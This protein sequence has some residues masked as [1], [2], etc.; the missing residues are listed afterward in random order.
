MEAAAGRA[1]AGTSQEAKEVCACVPY[2]LNPW[3]SIMSSIRKN[4]SSSS[5][6]VVVVIL[7]STVLA[8]ITCGY[9][10]TPAHVVVASCIIKGVCALAQPAVH[11]V[12]LQMR[13]SHALD[14]R[15]LLRGAQSGDAVVQPLQL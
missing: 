10:E 5:T 12:L 9:V 14:G 4:L 1:E 11:A 15:L 3:L 8:G 2:A 13:Q 7:L 6:P